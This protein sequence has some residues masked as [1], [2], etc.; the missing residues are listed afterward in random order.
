MTTTTFQES[1]TIAGRTVT[2]PPDLIL[3]DKDRAILIEFG[4]RLPPTDFQELIIGYR[5]AQQK[6]LHKMAFC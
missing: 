4:Q 2:V 6:S 3:S 1:Q 5:L